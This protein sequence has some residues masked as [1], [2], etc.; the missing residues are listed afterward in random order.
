MDYISLSKQVEQYLLSYFAE[1]KNNIRVYH[2]LEH[3]Q[4]VVT[5]ATQIANHYQLDDNDFFIVRTAAWFHD[6]GYF[7][8]PKQHEEKGAELAGEFLK[9]H[10]VD[11]ATIN[12][13]KQCVLATKMP[14]QPVGLLQQI[15]C[16][17]DL[18][19]FGTDEFIGRNKLMRK[20]AE[21][22]MGK[23]ISKDDWRNSTIKLMEEHHFHTDYA[24]LLLNDK[25]QQNIDELK[26]KE[27]KQLVKNEAKQSAEN[28]VA[29]TDG[30][31]V[32]SPK[33]NKNDRPERGVETMFRITSG[34]NQRLSDMAD[35]KAH[36][37]IQT[38]SI[39]I[40]VLLSVLLRKL[41][42][43]P[44]YTIPA[45][46]LL[47]I[48]VVTMVFSILATRPTV[49]HGTFTPTDIAEKRVNLLFFGN[50]YKMGFKDYEAGM[51]AMMEDR[52]FLYGSLT[53]DVYSQG[54]VLGRKY[55]LLRIAYNVFMYGI[56]VS[57][58]AFVVVSLIYGK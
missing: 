30:Q 54:V 58:L 32:V 3:T 49:P 40:S 9:E 28:A 7:I 12:A 43:Y 37:M 36:I 16:D 21:A 31:A 10:G 47:A 44:H 41:D 24:Q 42:E 34:N 38:N 19:H 57:V 20:E 13:V 5:A 23:E 6:V 25:Q 45:I 51:Q 27:E 2:T 48:C 15:V 39:I 29:S 17:A 52:E 35:S 11:E 18:F 50:F 1:N 26:K 55:R 4:S 53:R 14:Q 56:V 33:K 46:M 8:D 22:C